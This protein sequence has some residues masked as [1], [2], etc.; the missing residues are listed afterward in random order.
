MPNN[1]R[2][3]DDASVVATMEECLKKIKAMSAGLD[4]NLPRAADAGSD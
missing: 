2:K 1:K 3:R 4:E